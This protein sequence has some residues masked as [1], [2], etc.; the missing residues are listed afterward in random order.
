MKLYNTRNGIIIEHQECYYMAKE[1][2]W[3][4]L[5]NQKGLFER[6]SA[7]LSQLREDHSLAGNL[8]S[9]LLAPIGSQEVWAAGVTYLRSREAR[10]D[11]SKDAGG[12]DF[13]ARVY[14]AER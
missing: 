3:D 8:E 5:V 12:G 6:L 1:K 4:S 13:Y 2:N 10:M 11:E 14:E 7:G 9:G